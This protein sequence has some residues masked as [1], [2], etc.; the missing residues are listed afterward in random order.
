MCHKTRHMPRSNR[1][2]APPGRPGAIL[3]AIDG[4]DCRMQE[5]GRRCRIDHS[6]RYPA[7]MNAAR[8]IVAT[9]P[10]GSAH[11]REKMGA[12][13]RAGVRAEGQ[14]LLIT[15]SLDS[16]CRAIP[17]RARSRGQIVAR[18]C[19]D[20]RARI[21]VLLE[22]LPQRRMPGDEG[23]SLD[24]LRVSRKRSGELGIV[25]RQV[26]ERLHLLPKMRRDI[27][28]LEY[29]RGVALMDFTGDLRG[30]VLR[31]RGLRNECGDC[32]RSQ[33]ACDSFHAVT[34]ESDSNLCDQP[35]PCHGTKS[36][37]SR[38]CGGAGRSRAQT[39]T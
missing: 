2:R 35:V 11:A 32:E 31:H 19:N 17:G 24:Q 23:I 16:W 34:S 10:E 39:D 5:R 1:A 29:E 8:L 7:L 33:C 3:G 21:G 9:Q 12:P 6:A 20:V 28:A 4:A 37:R 14:R 26:A 22:K 18:I 30:G 36:W 13:A 25:L 15:G 27:S 38:E